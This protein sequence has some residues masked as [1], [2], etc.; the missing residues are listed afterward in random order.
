MKKGTQ[1]IPKYGEDLSGQILGRW[2]LLE[3]KGEGAA[4]HVYLA[5]AQEQKGWFRAVKIYFKEKPGLSSEEIEKQMTC[6]KQEAVLC[7]DQFHSH[8]IVVNEHP[9]ET[10]KHL[11]HVMQFA[12]G[13]NLRDK[14]DHHLSKLEQKDEDAYISIEEV[15]ELGIQIADGLEAIHRHNRGLV[16]RDICPS[17]ILIHQGNILIADLGVTQTRDDLTLRSQLGENAPRHP[18]H[19]AYMSPQ[20]ENERGP[21][22]Y[23]DDI[24]SVGCVLFE[25]LI[26]KQYRGPESLSPHPRHYRPDIPVWLD[27]IIAKCLQPARED[28]FQTAGELHQSLDARQVVVEEHNSEEKEWPDVFELADM[29][30]RIPK[31]TIAEGV[32]IELP[33]DLSYV[34]GDSDAWPQIVDAFFEPQ[35]RGG[36]LDWLQEDVIGKLIELR[37]RPLRDRM[38]E[39]LA[40]VKDAHSQVGEKDEPF[41][42]S[43]TLTRFLS[44]IP[45]FEKPEP[46]FKLDFGNVGIGETHQQQL[47]VNNIGGAV[48][49]GFVQ[50]PPSSSTLKVCEHAPF[51]CDPGQSVEFAL[52]GFSPDSSFL[53]DQPPVLTLMLYT[54]VGEFDIPVRYK[55]VPPR[56]EIS[57]QADLDFGELG[58]GE[59][60]TTSVTVKNTGCGRLECNIETSNPDLVVNSEKEFFCESGQATDVSLSFKPGDEFL[61]APP[62]E[63]AVRVHTNVGDFEL[64]A[65]YTILPPKIGLS[66]SLLEFSAETLDEPQELLITNTGHSPLIGSIKVQVPWLQLEPREAIFHSAP[67]DEYKLSI[68]LITG[69]LPGEEARQEDA[70]QL[71]TNAGDF[72]IGI[73]TPPWPYLAFEGG[74]KAHDIKSLIGLCEDHPQQAIRMLEQGKIVDWLQTIGAQEL[75]QKASQAKEKALTR[76]GRLKWFLD[77]SGVPHTY[78]A[79]I[80]ITPSSIDIILWG[81][82]KRAKRRGARSG[83]YFGS[84]GE[85]RGF[86]GRGSGRDYGDCPKGGEVAGIN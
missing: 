32:Q 77:E 68:S 83:A 15:Q 79:K 60:A 28:R 20:Q 2:R 73:S 76:Q 45:N 27:T 66:A 47:I 67:G 9:R 14:I 1:K 70:L 34:V 55:F 44:N 54:N 11:F 65:R 21:V 24:F 4:G 57:P 13:G 37:N 39:L 26:L 8:V 3:F 31:L 86:D 50:S 59:Q 63:S 36:F 84:F 42:K 38:E 7:K 69:K 81:K 48:L 16:H 72:E 29:V 85:D 10:K 64:P 30:G 41:L 61:S 51:R 78:L 40:Q 35:G 23:S 33:S 43:K 17:N 53:A 56:A 49:E 74:A 12:D 6:F 62:P 80:S 75:A 5:E 19:I 52:V 71:G 18:G 22:K 58:V 46:E 82:R 25:L